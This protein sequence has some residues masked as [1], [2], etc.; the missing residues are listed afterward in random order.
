MR[1][2]TKCKEMVEPEGYLECLCEHSELALYDYPLNQ[3]IPEQ[4]PVFYYSVS[5]HGQHLIVEYNREDGTIRLE[6]LHGSFAVPKGWPV[7]I[8]A[9]MHKKKFMPQGV[10]VE[11]EARVD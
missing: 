1:Y 3:T 6:D 7:F 2:C 4:S 5:R 11:E 10:E 8:P 9:G